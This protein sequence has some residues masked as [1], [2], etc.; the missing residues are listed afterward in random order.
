MIG[1]QCKGICNK[2]DS[3]RSFKTIESGRS[4]TEVRGAITRSAESPRLARRPFSV[5]LLLPLYPGK[6]VPPIRDL[7]AEKLNH[8][9]VSV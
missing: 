6:N 1:R 7:R 5:A 3:N 2:I 4:N 9:E 8:F